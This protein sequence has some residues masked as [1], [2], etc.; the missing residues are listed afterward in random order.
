[1][2]TTVFTTTLAASI[3]AV[4]VVGLIV[5][6]IARELADASERPVVRLFCERIAVFLPP[7]L[8]AFAFI[9]IMKVLEVID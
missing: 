5:F 6:L 2:V 9:V 8:V 3:S 1:M 7:L 4:T